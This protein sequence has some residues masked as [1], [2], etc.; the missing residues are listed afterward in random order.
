MQKICYIFFQATLQYILKS[1]SFFNFNSCDFYKKSVY[2][3][4]SGRNRFN[5]YII[6]RPK[7]KK[8]VYYINN[9]PILVHL[10]PIRDHLIIFQP[11]YKRK[12]ETFSMSTNYEYRVKNMINWLD[13]FIIK[14]LY[15]F[16]FDQALYINFKNLAN[17]FC[18][19]FVHKIIFSSTN[20]G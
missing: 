19:F 4:C 18:K 5:I 1:N 20:I 16:S 12:I 9:N 7:S 3:L 10:K 13:N 2:S 15:W 11:V 14:F 8:M 17:Y 6:A